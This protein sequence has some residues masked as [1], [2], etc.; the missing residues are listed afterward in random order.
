MLCV[1][2]RGGWDVNT[3]LCQFHVHT[4]SVIVCVRQR[5][6]VGVAFMLSN[7]SARL[8]PAKGLVSFGSS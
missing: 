3:V 8:V 1:C 5:T 4:I 6:C 7:M 2:V